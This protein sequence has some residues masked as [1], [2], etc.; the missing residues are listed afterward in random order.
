MRA[1]RGERKAAKRQGPVFGGFKTGA[2][3][4]LVGL[5]LYFWL[6]AADW[7]DWD[8]IVREAIRGLLHA[9]GPY[10]VILVLLLLIILVLAVSA[11]VALIRG[12][13]AEIRRLVKERD[14]LQEERGVTH[15]SSRKRGER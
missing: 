1:G 6:R 13:D 8:K 15:P 9:N 4:G 2:G 11:I 14:R 3:A 10:P 5:P 7:K 12:K